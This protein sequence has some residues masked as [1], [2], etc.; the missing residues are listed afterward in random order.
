[1]LCTDLLSPSL[2]TA[3]IITT[4]T[5]LIT[6]A[7]IHCL[8]LARLCAE[9]LCQAILADASQVVNIFIP[10]CTGEETGERRLIRLAEMA[11]QSQRLT[12]DCPSPK[13]IGHGALCIVAG[14]ELFRQQLTQPRAD[15][16][17]FFI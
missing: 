11:Q 3:V 8:P 7:A 17:V 1:M 12:Q 14:P 9:P 2:I 6:V 15:H 4:M 16:F 13:S 5:A 10:N